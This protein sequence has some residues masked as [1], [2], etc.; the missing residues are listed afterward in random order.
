MKNLGYSISMESTDEKLIKEYIDGKEESF[1]KLIDRYT[2]PI[3]NFTSR[4]AGSENAPDIVQDVFIK[5]WK[6]IR[7]FNSTKAH[8]KTWLFTIAKNTTTDY[9]R[10]K[11]SIIFSDMDTLNETFDQN[12]PDEEILPDEAIQKLQ[13]K[14]FLDKLLKQ[15]PIHYYSVLMLYYN[16]DMTF[17]E[18]GK[19][20]GKPLN[21]VKSHHHRALLQLKKMV[22][23]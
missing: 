21:T 22:D 12:I 13:D 16:E 2:G 10:K 17:A 14:N 1:K 15:L 8:F 19:V 18:I 6:N 3:Y 9:L 23:K 7:R 5:V 4:L 11:K 20:L